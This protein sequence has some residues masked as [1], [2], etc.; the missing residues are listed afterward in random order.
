[1]PKSYHDGKHYRERAEQC[2]KLAEQFLQAESREKMLKVASDYERLADRA[3]EL[4]SVTIR[5]PDRSAS[6]Q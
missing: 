2:R 6:G 3:D 5:S 1:M 4:A